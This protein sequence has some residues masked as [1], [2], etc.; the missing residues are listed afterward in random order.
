M[1]RKTYNTT[2]LNLS[3]NLYR[4]VFYHL[5]D[6][7]ASKDVVQDTFISLWENRDDVDEEKVVKWL[8]VVA[9]RKIY[10]LARKDKVVAKSREEIK[11]SDNSTYNEF[12]KQDSIDKCLALLP[13][14]QKT[15]IL[16]RDLEGYNY[17][18][19][20]EITN[21]S[22]AQVKVYLFRARQ[23]FRDS[24][25]SLTKISANEIY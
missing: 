6:L 10:N 20:G 11:H 18:E 5:K 19:I 12:D 7:D 24:Y 16:L 8:F 9:K 3:D 14:I 22:E 1:N 17:Q 4:F 2:V 23:K 13:D 15:V 21:L 25:E